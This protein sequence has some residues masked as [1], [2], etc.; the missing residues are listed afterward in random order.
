MRSRFTWLAALISLLGFAC[1][2]AAPVSSA[3]GSDVTVERVPVY[4]GADAFFPNTCPNVE[5]PPA[6]TVCEDSYLIFAREA[7]IINGGPASPDAT[8]WSVYA[9][10]YRSTWD[11]IHDYP[12]D[13][14][15]IR[16]GE[17]EISATAV[18]VDTVHLATASL[19]VSIPMDDGT[20]YNFDGTWRATEPQQVYGHDGPHTGFPPHYVD[21]CLTFIANGHQKFRWGE[22]TGTL[23]GEAVHSWISDPAS[24]AIFTGRYSYVT[25]PHGGCP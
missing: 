8:A 1:M 24:A 7:D 10:T 23:N 19:T 22:M 13:S 12:I 18:D 25:V 5:L 14:T 15:Y 2:T 16:S 20:T 9:D 11:G 17:V 6:G 3:A 21:R 4:G